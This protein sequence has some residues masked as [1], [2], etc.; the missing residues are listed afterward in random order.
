M[1]PGRKLDRKSTNR[2]EKHELDYRAKQWKCS[3]L[4]VILADMLSS[5][6]PMKLGADHYLMVAR[7]T[8]RRANREARKQ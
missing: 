3:K 7:S 1:K 2:R 8:L 5:R 4:A 6:S